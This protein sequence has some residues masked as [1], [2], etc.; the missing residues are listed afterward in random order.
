MRALG[1]ARRYWYLLALSLVMVILARL[2]RAYLPLI[3]TKA[4]IDSVLVQQHYDQL[5]Y[6]I[7]LIIA[8]YGLQSLLSFGQRYLNSY[9][10]QRVVFDLRNKLF[11][12]LQEKSFSFYDRTQTGQLLARTTTDVE[13][14]QRLY[15]FMITSLFGSVMEVALVIYFLAGIV[16][17]ILLGTSGT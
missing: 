11:A 3:G 13:G 8:L 4:V 1:Y 14:M 7:F 6:Y 9:L 15:S 10:S 5:N 2:M 12:S 16:N 17:R